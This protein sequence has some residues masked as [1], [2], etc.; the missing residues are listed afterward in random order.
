M[1]T[2]E[3]TEEKNK[4]K[5]QYNKNHYLLFD[6]LPEIGSMTFVPGGYLLYDEFINELIFYEDVV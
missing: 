5:V 1:I 3:I 4:F 2:C 6:E